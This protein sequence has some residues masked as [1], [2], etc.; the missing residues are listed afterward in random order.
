MS[1]PVASAARRGGLSSGKP[2]VGEMIVDAA[3]LGRLV[4]A[5]QLG[6]AFQDTDGGQ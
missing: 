4:E 5:Q 1:L 6:A 2:N 3:D